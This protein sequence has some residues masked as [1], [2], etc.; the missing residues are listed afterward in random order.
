[1][2]TTWHMRQCTQRIGLA[3]LMTLSVMQMPTTRSGMH[4]TLAWFSGGGWLMLLH[5]EDQP[6]PRLAMDGCATLG[7]GS[8]AR[9]AGLYQFCIITNKAPNNNNKN[10]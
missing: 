9:G 4:A 7:G 5:I 8:D 3:R 2:H 10:S 6:E 1:M